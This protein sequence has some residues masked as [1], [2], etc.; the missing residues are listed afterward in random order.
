MKS[1]STSKRGNMKVNTKS[2]DNLWEC[3]KLAITLGKFDQAREYREMYLG[4][5]AQAGSASH[6]KGG[7]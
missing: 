7:K 1:N 2:L 3:W 6:I 4:L 5:L